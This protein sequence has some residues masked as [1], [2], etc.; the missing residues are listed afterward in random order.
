[1]SRDWGSTSIVAVSSVMSIVVV[2]VGSSVFFDLTSGGG[3]V[4]KGLG[5]DEGGALGFE[6]SFLVLVRSFGAFEDGEEVFSLCGNG[7]S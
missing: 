1:M 7:F 3:G 6:L 2:I 5:A 4:V